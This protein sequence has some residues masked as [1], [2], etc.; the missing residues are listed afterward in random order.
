[1]KD[2]KDIKIIIAEDHEI[3]LDVLKNTI[4]KNYD[5]Q[6]I[7]TAVNGQDLL[8]KLTVYKPDLILLDIRMPIMDGM[9]AAIEIKKNYPNI[10]II[11]LTMHSDLSIIKEMMDIGIHGYILKNSDIKEIINSIEKVLEGELYYGTEVKE[12][13]IEEV[14][15][16][17][18]T[19]NIVISRIEKEI[20]SLVCAGNTDEQISQQLELNITTIELYLKKLFI[21]IKL[22]N[23]EDLIRYAY[24][25]NLIEI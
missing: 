25:N 6:V 18:M 16:K 2:H 14:V 22:D 3:F 7:A 1:M 21:R 15:E 13:L 10:K 11:M 20:L 17:P 23:R 24:E 12:S 5:I 9:E 4:T 8:Q 19:D